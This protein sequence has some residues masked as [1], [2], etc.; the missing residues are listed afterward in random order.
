M[1]YASSLVPDLH[2]LQATLGQLQAAATSRT[3]GMIGADIA[4]AEPWHRRA[5]GNDL[6]AAVLGDT[7]G[8]GRGG[9]RCRHLR[10]GRTD[11]RV[12]FLSAAAAGNRVLIAIP[13]S[14]YFSGGE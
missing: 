3:G 10:H 2:C 6:R 1:F 8:L 11:R 7:A 5:S 9:R 13:E 4:K 14:D 12:A